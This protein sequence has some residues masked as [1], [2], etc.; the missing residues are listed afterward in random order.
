MNKHLKLI[1]EFHDTRSMKISALE[2]SSH[3]SDMDI[4]KY[5]AM[6]MKAGSDVLQAIKAGEMVEILL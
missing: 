2:S 4:V 1:S 3:F 6:L 5:Q